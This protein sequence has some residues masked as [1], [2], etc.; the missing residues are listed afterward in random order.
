MLRIDCGSAGTR[1][2]ETARRAIETATRRSRQV[3]FY[4]ISDLVIAEPGSTLE[5]LRQQRSEREAARE[6]LLQKFRL[7]RKKGEASEDFIARGLAL[8]VDQEAEV[9][10]EDMS[11]HAPVRLDLHPWTPAHVA[12]LEWCARRAF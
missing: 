10:I 6:A 5:D 11:D 12:L 4:W 8:A 9:T 7:E 1:F 2:D 3:F